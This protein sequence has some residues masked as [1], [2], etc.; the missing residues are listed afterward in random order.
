MF[1]SDQGLEFDMKYHILHDFGTSTPFEA[2]SSDHPKD[3]HKLKLLTNFCV[4][5]TSVVGELKI[6]C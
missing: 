2:T 5:L 1:H 4:N 6:M 3:L